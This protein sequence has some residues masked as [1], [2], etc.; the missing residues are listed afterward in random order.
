MSAKSAVPPVP[1]GY[2]DLPE[3]GPRVGVDVR[4]YLHWKDVA[5]RRLWFNTSIMSLDYSETPIYTTLLASDIVHHIIQY[6]RDDDGVPIESRKIIKLYINSPGGMQ[7]EGTGLV[8][9]ILASE[10][11]VYTYNVGLCA[12]MAFMIYIA[13]HRRFTF[14]HATFLLHDGQ[15]GGFTSS[16]KFQD[17]ADFGKRYDQEVIKEIILKQ[18]KITEKVYKDYLRIEWYMLPKD[19]LKYGVAHQIINS[20]SEII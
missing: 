10:T 16:S 9:A 8:D 11:P 2:F 19:A 6:N 18:T 3:P 20:I 17:T 7:F 12:S 15:Q 4:E 5:E 1:K 14:P 13:G